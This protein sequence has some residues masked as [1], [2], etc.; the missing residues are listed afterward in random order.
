MKPLIF[1]LL[2]LCT[3]CACAQ[4]VPKNAGVIVV[5]GVHFSRVVSQLTD[6]SGYEIK[7]LNN[8]DF[9]VKTKFKKTCGDCITAISI[10]VRVVDSVASITGKWSVKG[11]FLSGLRD[12]IDDEEFVYD[13]KNEK[14][15]QAKEAFKAMNAFALSLKSEIS[16]RVI[17]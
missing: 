9:I 6:S 7:K 4:E 5:K 10:N 12:K 8:E 11:G 2:S 13:I 17:E 14:G 16:Y 3:V 1:F 15:K